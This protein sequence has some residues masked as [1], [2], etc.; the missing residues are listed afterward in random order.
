M[1]PPWHQSSEL[2]LLFQIIRWHSPILGDV[3]KATNKSSTSGASLVQQ[4]GIWYRAWIIEGID[5]EEKERYARKMSITQSLRWMNS[6]SIYILRLSFLVNGFYSKFRFV[7]IQ[8]WRFFCDFPT[9]ET[10]DCDNCWYQRRL[11]AQ[12]RSS[13]PSRMKNF[14]IA[15]SQH[16]SLK[17][18]S[19][20]K[21]KF[22][23]EIWWM[24]YLENLTNLS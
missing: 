14:N 3:T 24:F 16:Y 23:L 6:H 9:E 22:V 21:L 19:G 13:K 4:L 18:L 2:D 8:K 10:D 1:C 17:L 15:A 20:F 7:E 5:S 12:L 11:P